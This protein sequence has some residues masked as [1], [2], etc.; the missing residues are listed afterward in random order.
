MEKRMIPLES[1]FVQYLYY[2]YPIIKR[3]S[4]ETASRAIEDLQSGIEALSL[5]G[6][7]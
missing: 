2:N 6:I 5:T 1:R 3:W 4:L 7:P